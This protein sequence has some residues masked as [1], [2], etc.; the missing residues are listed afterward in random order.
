[1][2]SVRRVYEKDPESLDGGILIM[3]GDMESL[4][5]KGRKLLTFEYL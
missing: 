4:I 3:S 2:R 5:M 1:M